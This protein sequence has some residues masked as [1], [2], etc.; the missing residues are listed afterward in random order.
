MGINVDDAWGTL[1]KTVVIPEIGR[2]HRNSSLSSVLRFPVERRDGK[3]M[4]VFSEL[5][6]MDKWL[7]SVKLQYVSGLFLEK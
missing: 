7:G 3:G 2:L 5:E 4:W 6:A 1:I